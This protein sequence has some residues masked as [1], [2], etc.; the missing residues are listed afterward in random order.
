MLKRII[1][2][3]LAMGIAGAAIAQN[4]YSLQGSFVDSKNQSL[5]FTNCVLLKAAD[6]SFAY[7]TTSDL[8]GVFSLTGVNQGNYILRISAIGHETYWQDIT[9]SQDTTLDAITIAD[10]ATL[11]KTVEI[12]ASRPLYSAD[13]EKVFYNVG[14][15]PSVQSGCCGPRA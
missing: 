1:M 9:I 4:T 7:G 12:T 8:D 6:S 5:P 11:L 3:V 13:G 2:A 15:D 10:N 14:D